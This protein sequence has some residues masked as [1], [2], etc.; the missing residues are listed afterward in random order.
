MNTHARSLLTPKQR[1][2]LG[3]LLKLVS[4]RRAGVDALRFNAGHEDDLEEMSRL[5]NSRF[6]ERRDNQYIVR[7][8][9]LAELA[10]TNAIAD[11]VMH[12]CAHLFST[13]R[14]HYKHHPGDKISI[15][16]LALE[17]DLPESEVRCAL[18]YLVEQGIWDGRSVDLD[19]PDAYVIPGERILPYKSLGAVVE[20]LRG[21]ALASA[22]AT[23]TVGGGAGR[24]AQ[25]RNT[26]R[27][28]PVVR[29]AAQVDA[30]RVRRGL[31]VD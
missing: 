30:R 18:D 15:P 1:R 27:T 29:T 22:P 23:G 19:K 17:A 7:L 24:E 9:G 12:L 2:L 20:Q 10:P 21:W 28:S 16:D 6:L 13:L 3:E 25:P 4:K 11:S 8:L 26:G 5:E 14:R 31:R